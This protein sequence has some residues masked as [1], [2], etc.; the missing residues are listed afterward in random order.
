MRID[1][2]AEKALKDEIDVLHLVGGVTLKFKK[3]EKIGKGEFGFIM[4]GIF[5]S[6]LLLCVK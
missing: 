3:L 6:L 5:T 2:V 1:V 4:R